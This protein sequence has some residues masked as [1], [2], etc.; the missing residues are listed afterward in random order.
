MQD[1]APAGTCTQP[2][3]LQVL[4]GLTGSALPNG[5]ATVTVIL[6]Q[7]KHTILEGTTADTAVT[8]L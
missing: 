2:V 7:V 1:I 3:H 4:A 6:C 5:A 8:F